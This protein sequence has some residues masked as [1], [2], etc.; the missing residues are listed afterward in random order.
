MRLI[1]PGGMLALALFAACVLFATPQANADQVG[2][3]RQNADLARKVQ[4]CTALLG[5]L[6]GVVDDHPWAY[7][8]RANGVCWA[9]DAD[10]A[11]ADIW[12][13]FDIDPASIRRMQGKLAQLGFFTAEIDG[14]FSAE[15]DTAVI[16][17]AAAGCPEAD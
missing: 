5:A 9:G 3:C 14:G 17:W 10:R 4:G 16:A 12:R 2:D 7:A 1:R 8:E 15:L 11:V 13:W 6:D